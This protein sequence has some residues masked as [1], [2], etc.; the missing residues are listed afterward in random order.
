[1]PIH[2]LGE[3]IAKHRRARG[4]S[5]EDLATMIGRSTRTVRRWE[6]G[7][8]SLNVAALAGIVGCTVEDLVHTIVGAGTTARVEPAKG[9]DNKKRASKKSRPWRAG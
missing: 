4:L 9:T 8:G 1:M 2:A 6:Q 7:I 5:Q 3:Q